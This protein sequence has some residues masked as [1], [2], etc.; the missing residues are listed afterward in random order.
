MDSSISV[1][2]FIFFAMNCE[3]LPQKPLKKTE[4]KK[5]AKSFIFKNLDGGIKFVFLRQKQ[6]LVAFFWKKF[7]SNKSFGK[8]WKVSEKIGAFKFV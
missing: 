1:K 2:V 8:F 3:N 7:A 4:S 6:K 5:F